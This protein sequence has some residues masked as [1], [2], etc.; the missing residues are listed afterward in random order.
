M[1]TNPHRIPF[2]WKLNLRTSIDLRIGITTTI[3]TFKWPIRAEIATYRCDVVSGS[4]YMPELHG[5]DELF[6]DLGMIQDI[7]AKMKATKESFS[8]QKH[9]SVLEI[10]G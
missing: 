7:T 8:F 1:K 10:S 4:L 3:L 6:D 9:N 5:F 2:T